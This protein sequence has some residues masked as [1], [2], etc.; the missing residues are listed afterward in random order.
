MRFLTLGSSTQPTRCDQNY[1]YQRRT[2]GPGRRRRSFHIMRGQHARGHLDTRQPRRH[3][4]TALPS[5]LHLA[6]SHKRPYD[7]RRTKAN[8]AFAK[9]TSRTVT[10]QLIQISSWACDVL[11]V[12]AARRMKPGCGVLGRWLRCVLV[13][14]T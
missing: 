2:W 8:P 14:P 1:Q 12:T 6:Q 5:S 11:C 13:T 7:A 4:T 9:P 3:R 10:A